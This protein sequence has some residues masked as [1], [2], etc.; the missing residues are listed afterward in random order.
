MNAR[1]LDAWLS[2]KVHVCA[3]FTAS[4][5]TVLIAIT[6]NMASTA[7]AAPRR[8]PVAPFVDDTSNGRCLARLPSSCTL[9][10]DS[11]NSRGIYSLQ[12]GALQEIT[13]RNGGHV[14]ILA[15]AHWVRSPSETKL[16]TIVTCVL[17]KLD[18]ATTAIHKHNGNS[19]D[20]TCCRRDGTAGALRRNS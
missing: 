13:P 16:S 15:C 5:R 14:I 17:R 11:S 7:P 20:Q 19:S 18:T 3:C 2:T 4:T 12:Y 1:R 6:L 9:H 10:D 8:W